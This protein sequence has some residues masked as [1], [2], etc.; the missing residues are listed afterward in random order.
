MNESG[1]QEWPKLAYGFLTQRGFV[2][3]NT[4]RKKARP[5]L[6]LISPWMASSPLREYGCSSQASM[7]SCI[8]S[9]DHALNFH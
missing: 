7:D 4:T 3:V 2:H 8:Q 9:L 6:C 5:G 1:R